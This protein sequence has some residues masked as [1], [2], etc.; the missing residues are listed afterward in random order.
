LEIAF[1]DVL[2]WRMPVGVSHFLEDVIE[3]I[4]VVFAFG[5]QRKLVAP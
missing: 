4:R 3:V 1:D 2:R 5:I